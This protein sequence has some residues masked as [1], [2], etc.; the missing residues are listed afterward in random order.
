[1]IRV[2]LADDHRLLRESLRRALTDEG[3][4]VVG[5]AADGEEAVRLAGELAPD[6]VLLDVTMPNAGRRRGRRPRSTKPRR[7]FAS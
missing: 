4:D 3:F 1:M 6:V 7:R 2:L 5:E